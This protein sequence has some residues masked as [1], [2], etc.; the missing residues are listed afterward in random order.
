MKKYILLLIGSTALALG[1]FSCN[2]DYKDGGRATIAV[3]I[4]E[5]TFAGQKKLAGKQ[6]AIQPMNANQE[7]HVQRQN[8][9]LNDNLMIIAE[10]SP[11]NE[12]Q[13]QRLQASSNS[14]KRAAVQQDLQGDVRYK[15]LVYANNGTYVTERDYIRNREN[16]TPELVLDGGQSYTF[17]AY[18]VNST[19]DLPAVNFGDPAN[20]T[21]SNSSLQNVSGNADLMYFKRQM[22]LNSGQN[23]LNIVLTHQFSRITSTIDA[24]ATGFPISALTA[25]FSTHSPFA[26]LQL[27]DGLLTRLGTAVNN[28]VT[29][30]TGL[31]SMVV[32]G[33]PVL[34]NTNTTTGSFILGSIKIG[35]LTQ[36]N[37]IPFNAL[38]IEPGVDYTLTLTIAVADGY[39]T[40]MGIPVVSINGKVWM[41]HNLGADY[42]LDPD[43][44]PS[45]QGLI[46]NY[47]QWGRPAIVA[48]GFTN[49]NIISGW[50]SNEVTDA[51]LWN[52][53]TEATP[54]KTVND[55][56]PDGFRVPT[57]TEYF[58]LVADATTS[59]IGNWTGGDTN[60]SAAKV[61]TSKR[62]ADVVMTLPSGGYRNFDQGQLL[63]RAQ[64]SYYWFTTTTAGGNFNIKSTGVTIGGVAG[65][66]T[67]FG[68]NIRCIKE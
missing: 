16:L 3:N 54:I 51:T 2:K 59:N 41:R 10:L 5:T 40:H 11:N 49:P 45:V 15:L 53:G 57:R 46:G 43:Q 9:V 17:V 35:S 26:N 62:K 33:A 14:S 38:V 12:R 48:D 65:G 20:K 44:N 4:A 47:Y 7:Q 64:D 25:S 28:P 27:E 66:M 58:R 37:K 32:K 34:L 52:S 21:L 55:P 8:V 29:S 22:T 60:Y 19:T 39:S 42:S 67:T 68:R 36:T 30:F 13:Q 1:L 61:L 63:G 31:N 50:T 6:A 24:T 23:D 18:S 56:C